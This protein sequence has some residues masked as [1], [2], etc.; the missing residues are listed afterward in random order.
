MR[1]FY[2]ITKLMHLRVTQQL[3]W[4]NFNNTNNNNNIISNFPAVI[5]L[6]GNTTDTR[7]YLKQ[8][9]TTDKNFTGFNIKMSK[10][11]AVCANCWTPVT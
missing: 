7:T 11:L 1:I 5:I 3:C 6:E 8:T 2:Y 10:V 9:Y 4:R